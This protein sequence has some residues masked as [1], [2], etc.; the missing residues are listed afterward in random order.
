[1]RITSYA[2]Q[3]PV[4]PQARGRGA[5]AADDTSRPT[6]NGAGVVQLS[7]TA[8]LLGTARVA[9]HAELAQRQARF[10]T[11]S[12]QI[13]AGSYTVDREELCSALLRGSPMTEDD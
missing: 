11:L 12:N 9:Y 4:P 6:H 2:A 8:R 5:S 10:E 1:M 7:P 13:A 3:Q